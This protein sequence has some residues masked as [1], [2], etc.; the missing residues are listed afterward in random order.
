MS[1]PN[2]RSLELPRPPPS[3]MRGPAK[4]SG[5]LPPPLPSPLTL[6]RPRLMPSRRRSYWPLA[7]SAFREL[8]W[9][10]ERIPVW[11][12]QH[13]ELSCLAKPSQIPHPHLDRN[14]SQWDPE[15]SI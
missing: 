7:W 9:P 2:A 10:L 14:R 12:I 13:T 8:T 5:K 15:R 6:P 11:P 3:V 1:S 4:V